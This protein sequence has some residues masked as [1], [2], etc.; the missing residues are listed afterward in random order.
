MKN[1]PSLDANTSGTRGGEASLLVYVNSSH[2]YVIFDPRKIEESQISKSAQKNIKAEEPG[3][4]IVW[5]RYSLCSSALMSYLSR[6]S[7]RISFLRASE[8]NFEFFPF[9]PR[10][11]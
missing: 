1:D 6:D 7:F 4:F 3:E 9:Y 11:C 5:F 10:T 8:N 2:E